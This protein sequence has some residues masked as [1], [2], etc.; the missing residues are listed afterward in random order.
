MN[1]QP[2]TKNLY[3]VCMGRKNEFKL[4]CLHAHQIFLCIDRHKNTSVRKYR[5]D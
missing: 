1:M 2:F 4:E 3:E 5:K